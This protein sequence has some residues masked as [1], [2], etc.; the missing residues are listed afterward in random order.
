MSTVWWLHLWLND[1]CSEKCLCMISFLNRSNRIAW[2]SQSWAV[3]VKNIFCNLQLGKLG[4]MVIFAKFP[5]TSG[6]FSWNK[7]ANT[8]RIEGFTYI[9]TYTITSLLSRKPVVAVINIWKTLRKSQN[10][11][12]NHLDIF[13]HI[14]LIM[15][16]VKLVCVCFLATCILVFVVFF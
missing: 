4:Y 8:L 12:G 3:H 10:I 9:Y 7:I 11:S 1:F 13:L 14:L 16:S 5:L 15:L 6:M 2:L